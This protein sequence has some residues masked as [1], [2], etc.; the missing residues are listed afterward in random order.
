MCIRDSAW[1]PSV[2]DSQWD[3]GKNE[4]MAKKF[5]AKNHGKLLSLSSP[6]YGGWA[7]HLKRDL[8]LIKMNFGAKNFFEKNFFFEKF[9]SHFCVPG[10]RFGPKHPG[11]VRLVVLQGLHRNYFSFC[12]NFRQVKQI[13]QSYGPKR[14]F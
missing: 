12:L 3:A 7:K 9:L 4:F 14:Y 6:H 11:V 1:S 10:A 2:C 5:F 13:N 8:Q